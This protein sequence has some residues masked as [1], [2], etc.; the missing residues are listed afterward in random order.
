MLDG[1]AA[2]FSVVFC[3]KLFQS[4]VKC[5]PVSFFGIS[6]YISGYSQVDFLDECL[7]FLFLSLFWGTLSIWLCESAHPR[8]SVR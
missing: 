7:F 5:F 6:I 3:I 4:S 8:R 1:T 2:V